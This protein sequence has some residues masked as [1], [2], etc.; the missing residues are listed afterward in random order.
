MVT[1]THNGTEDSFSPLPV[2]LIHT[3][4]ELIASLAAVCRRAGIPL[5]TVGRIAEIE[6][7]P[8]GHIV[9]TDLERTT[10]LWREVGAAHV[11]AVVQSPAE[12]ATAIE[13]GATGWVLARHAAVG[14]L[15]LAGAAGDC[16][17]LAE[18]GR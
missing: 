3:D 11:L 7:W 15:A 8:V 14:L 12:G 2:L 1:P 10:P 9:V 13:R 4:P 17:L 5:L 18:T 6:R 16:T